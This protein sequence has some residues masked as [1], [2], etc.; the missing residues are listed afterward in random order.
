MRQHTLRF[1]FTILA[2][3]ATLGWNTPMFPVA[4][5]KIICFSVEIYT[6]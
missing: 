4:M 6:V 5:L 3:F 1:I 2:I